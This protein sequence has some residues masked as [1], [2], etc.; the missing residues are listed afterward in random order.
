MSLRSLKIGAGS[1]PRMRGTPGDGVKDGRIYGI[2][3]A[4]AGNTR[5][6][7]RPPARRRD[8]PRVCGEHMLTGLVC[9]VISGSS[10]RMRGTLPPDALSLV[11]VGIIPAYAGNTYFGRWRGT[12][13]RDHPRVCGEHVSGR[14]Y[15]SILLGSS[16]RMRGTLGGHAWRVLFEGII[17]AYAGNT[18]FM[19][20]RLACRRDHPRVCGEHVGQ[21]N[22][23]ACTGGSSPRMRGTRANRPLTPWPTGIIPAYAGNTM[24]A[25]PALPSTRDHPRVCGEHVHCGSVFLAAWGSSPRMRGTPSSTRIHPTSRGII[26]AYAGNTL[27]LISPRP[28][29]RDHPRVCGEHQQVDEGRI[30]KRGSSPRMR[31]TPVLVSGSGAVRGIIPAYAGNTYHQ[32]RT[33][34][35]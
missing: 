25:T 10:P 34:K 33:V 2:I 18:S 15:C 4:Y 35:A 7:A 20:N 3:P 1:S 19:F 5:R 14:K 13:L 21:V 23:A 9:W 22:D 27:S 16:P 31:G 26:P 11:Y 32:P 29:C 8:H 6:S 12:A 28:C 24:C 30:R 17:P